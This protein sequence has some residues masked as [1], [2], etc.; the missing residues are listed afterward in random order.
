M[1]EVRS[2]TGLMLCGGK[3][4]V[5][6]HRAGLDSNVLKASNPSY[7]PGPQGSSSTSMKGPQSLCFRRA[8]SYAFEALALGSCQLLSILRPGASDPVSTLLR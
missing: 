8:A 7:T 4:T 2:L 3:K 5:F 6:E 1:G